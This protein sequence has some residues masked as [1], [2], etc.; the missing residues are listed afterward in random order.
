MRERNVWFGAV[1][2][3]DTACSMY[4]CVNDTAIGMYVLCTDSGVETKSYLVPA[5]YSAVVALLPDIDRC[6]E[7][8]YCTVLHTSFY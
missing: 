1:R 6:L 4:V 8:S 3:H 7:Q 5:I 2:V